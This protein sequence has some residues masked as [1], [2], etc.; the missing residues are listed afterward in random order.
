MVE[1]RKMEKENKVCPLLLIG[2][3]SNENGL[4]DCKGE[5]CQWWCVDR[6]AICG[7]SDGCMTIASLME[8]E[9]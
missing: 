8:M 4:A 3:P 7:V 9:V 5:K 2:N 1:R 6:C